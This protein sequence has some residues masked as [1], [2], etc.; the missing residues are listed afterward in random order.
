MKPRKIISGLS[1]AALAILAAL[2]CGAAGHHRARSEQAA[3][4]AIMP[5]ITSDAGTLL[6]E[7]DMGR[8]PLLAAINSAAR[9]IDLVI[10]EITDGKITD[11]LIA[12]AKRGAA[13]RVL[14]NYD[15]FKLAKHDPNAKTIKKL[16]KAGVSMRKAP[17][18]F[19]HTHQ[20]TFIFDRSSAIIM[21]FNLNPKHFSK[22]RDFGFITSAAPEVAEIEQVFEADWGGAKAAPS[23]PSL[24]WSPDNARSKILSMINSAGKSLDLY[25][26]EA[27]DRGGLKAL[28]D[29]AARGV[30][31]RFITPRLK[32]K[33]TKDVNAPGRKMLA[34]KGVQ[35]KVGKALYYHA[36]MIL[37]DYGAAG[38]TAFLGSQNLSE[39]SLDRNRELGIIL[40]DP[41]ILGAL[42]STF[43]KDW[44]QN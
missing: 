23:D 12:A 5:P 42:S 34:A 39:T 4:R 13:V 18:S 16:D 35:V 1:L 36:K 22:I 3:K 40:G 8:E 28:C 17:G 7:P 2:P 14:Y 31:V 27:L 26:E 21:T 43:E 30:T 38:Q 6:V 37:A 44:A 33:S 10:Y 32:G 15:S 19:I 41:A 11:A 25:S 24:V 20:K 29:A 9:S